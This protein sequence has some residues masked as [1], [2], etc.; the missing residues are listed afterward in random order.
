MTQLTTFNCPHHDWHYQCAFLFYLVLTL[1][2]EHSLL[3]AQV[4][5]R[6]HVSET[7]PEGSWLFHMLKAAVTQYL[8][9]DLSFVKPSCVSPAQPHSLTQHDISQ[10]C[11]RGRHVS[12]LPVKQSAACTTL[13][14]CYVL[15]ELSENRC[16]LTK[17][18]W[19]SVPGLHTCL[20]KH[21]HKEV[22]GMCLF[23][24][25]IMGKW[26]ISSNITL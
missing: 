6:R 17:T 8:H 24:L 19:R 3:S 1:L 9:G 4:L 5:Q 21:T 7:R 15:S 22:R 13:K 18:I 11:Q 16:R 26:N 14:V 25:S 12:G 20:R 23:S 10:A 2:N